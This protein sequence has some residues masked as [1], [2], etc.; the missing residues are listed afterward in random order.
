LLTD[1]GPTGTGSPEVRS[2]DGNTSGRLVYKLHFD[3]PI[4][5]FRFFASWSQWGMEGDTVGGVEYSA[6][7]QKWVGI[8][9][10]HETKIVDPLVVHNSF[11]ASGLKTQDLYIRCYSRDKNHPEAE[12]GPGRW[13]KLRMAGDP[14]WGDASRTFFKSQFQ[15]WLIPAK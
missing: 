14:A 8:R 4:S 9:D 7:G 6:D 15:V 11:M 10:V 13:M 5:G 2:I 12:S 1:P 3:K